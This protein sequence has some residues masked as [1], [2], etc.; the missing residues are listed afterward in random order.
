MAW[1]RRVEHRRVGVVGHA[2]GQGTEPACGLDGGD[3]VGRGAAGGH[4]HERV[5]RTHAGGLDVVARQLGVILGAL[6]AARDRR[7]PAGHDGRDQLGWDAEGGHALDRVDEG[8]PPAGAG[9]RVEQAT[10]IAQTLGDGLDEGGDRRQGRPDRAAGTEASSSFIRVTI[11][12]ALMVSSAS[13]RGFERFGGGAVCRHQPSI[14]RPRLMAPMSTGWR[15]PVNVGQCARAAV[16]GLV[17]QHGHGHGLLLVAGVAEVLVGQQAGLGQGCAEARHEHGV[18]RAATG[19]DDLVRR[20][21]QEAA[22]GIG[23]RVGR[24]GRDAWPRCPRR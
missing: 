21:R 20:H 24:V 23:D 13:D 15:T 11:S 18:A 4:A 7:L 14:R 16:P 19:G 22:V 5:S 12:S 17:G 3:D 10:A 1:S 9:A 2:G 8:Q 6:D